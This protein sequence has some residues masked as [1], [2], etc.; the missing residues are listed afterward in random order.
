[1]SRKAYTLIIIYLTA[2]ALALG[3]YSAV[4]S[5]KGGRYRSTAVYGY[6][7]AFG[8]VVQAA[9]SLD[10]ALRRASYAT[11]PEL[12]SSVCA[13]IYGCCLAAQM[14]MAALPFSTE[15]LEQTAGF[16][17]IAGDYACSLIR[18]RAADGFGDTER[19]N[20]AA[21]AGISASL[22]EG[23]TQLQSDIRDGAVIMDEPENVFADTSEQRLMSQVLLDFEGSFPELPELEYD[24]KYAVMAEENGGAIVSEDEAK[25]AAAELFGFDANGLAAQYRSESGSVCFGFDGGTVIVDGDGHVLSMSSERAV[26]GRLTDTE[27]EQAAVGFIKDAGFENMELDSA[28][29]VNDVLYAEFVCTC[30]EI[31]CLREVIRV[32]VAAD[33][34]KIYSYDAR[35]YMKNHLDREPE[36]PAVTEHEAR[37]ALPEELR[38]GDTRLAYIETEGGKE[39]LCYAF[40]CTGRDG[41]SVT[42][43]V[44][45]STAR[46]YRIEL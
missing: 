36:E 15:E 20:M 7:H 35:Q 26:A 45:A 34:G 5:G 39:L 32:G 9:D 16:V 1:M 23:L 29:R 24:G 18:S 6:E 28:E 33:T 21:L 22:T 31:R 46:Q 14:T 25:R 43:Y 19:N 38:V 42:V 40:S 3:A 4:L 12:S 10:D 13:E 27:L 44:D 8:E 41:E 11:G 30:G 37:S 2:A 17:G